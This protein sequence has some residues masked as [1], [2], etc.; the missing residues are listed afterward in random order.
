MKNVKGFIIYVLA[1]FKKKELEK[2]HNHF[3]INKIS[4]IILTEENKFNEEFTTSSLDDNLENISKT[5]I[6]IQYGDGITINSLEDYIKLNRF[7]AEI[8]DSN[9]LRK[10]KKDDCTLRN[11]HA[12]K[13]FYLTLFWLLIIVFIIY[14]KGFKGFKTDH[15]IL[16]KTEFIVVIGTLTTSIFAFYMA[17]IRYLFYKPNK[18]SQT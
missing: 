3:D 1:Y 5:E 11:K 16:D 6:G 14:L 13:A 10:A 15:F 17:V 8:Q 2:E 18:D 7:L 4:K 9:Q 12:K